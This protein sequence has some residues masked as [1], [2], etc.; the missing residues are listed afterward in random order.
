MRLGAYVVET[1]EHGLECGVEKDVERAKD[2][3]VTSE[4][5]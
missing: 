1:D 5:P 2:V 3:V 4:T